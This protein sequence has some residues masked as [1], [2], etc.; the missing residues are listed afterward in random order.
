MKPGYQFT[1][2]EVLPC[3][4][5]S[6]TVVVSLHRA[7]LWAEGRGI[8]SDLLVVK[9]EDILKLYETDQQNMLYHLLPSGI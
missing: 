5:N 3:V 8:A 6:T 7:E 2:Y 4:G 9:Q 1:V